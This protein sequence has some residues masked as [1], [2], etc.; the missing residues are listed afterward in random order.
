MSAETEPQPF[1]AEL[2]GTLVL[3]FVAVGTAVLAAEFVGSV[4][5]ALA[6]AFTLFALAY[7]IGP[8]SGSHVNPAVTLG[9]LLAG[10]IG[11]RAAALYWAAQF[12]GAIVGAAL[13]YLVARQVP[14]LETTGAFGTNGFGH[15]SAVGISGGG[16][17]LAEAMLTS[18]LVYV[19]LAVT[20]RLTVQ[21]VDGLPLGLA[22]GAV[23]LVGVPLTGAS[24][25]PARSLAPA[26]FAGSSAL[27]Q[28]WLFLLA[29][30]VGAAVAVVVHRIV[31]PQAD[32]WLPQVP[33][34]PRWPRAERS[35]APGATRRT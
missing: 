11:I 31:H 25:N 3:V 28:V 30:L 27:A 7:A 16:A 32:A 4:G 6:F 2:L 5:I 13:L 19:W 26:L 35:T 20:P 21:G 34:W 12:V 15:R 18:L 22:I 29:P 8:I 24:V 1:A 33:V 10:R 14:G 17:F 9:M 23:H